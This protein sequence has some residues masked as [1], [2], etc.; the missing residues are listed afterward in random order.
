MK[1]RKRHSPEQI[2]RKLRP[3]WRKL[4][5]RLLAGHVPGVLVQHFNTASLG[6]LYPRSRPA[7]FPLS[8][9]SLP[10]IGFPI[11]VAHSESSQLLQR[12]ITGCQLA[13]LSD[14]QA[15]TT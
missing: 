11:V 6:R 1:N 7:R 3:A 15:T 9:K 4:L 12:A 8:G 13:E 10:P 2:V 14:S 5:R